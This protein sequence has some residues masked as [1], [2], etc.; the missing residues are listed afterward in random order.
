M[1]METIIGGRELIPRAAELIKNGDIVAFPTETVYG[2]GGDAL[3]ESAIERIYEAKNR[4]KDN[5]FIVHVADV[6]Q[7]DRVAYVTEEAAKVFAEFAPGPITVVLKKRDCV[8][9]A[10]TAGLDTVGVRIPSHPMCREFLLACGLPVAAP[11]A[12][13]SKRVSP[14]RAEYVY[15]DMKGR[16]KLILDGGACDVGIESTVLSLAGEVPTILR[17]GIITAEA[18]IKFLPAVKIHT[19]EVKI[20]QAPGMK[21]KHYAPAVPC[22]MFEEAAVAAAYADQWTSEGLKTVI[23][24]KGG[25]ERFG[26]RNAISLGSDGREIA[27]NVFAYLRMCEKKYDRI[28]IEKLSDREEE[29]AVMNRI[30]KSC[31]GNILR[32]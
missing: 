1:D 10:A 19:G 2:L 15:D 16:I 31:D 21:Y 4:P 30:L 8:P 32:D 9:Y 20:A 14:T 7:A 27:R 13:V 29:G 12:N 22:F 24:C 17:P 5:P 26:G 11:S 18:L 25:T 3:N 6:E 28:L 23:L